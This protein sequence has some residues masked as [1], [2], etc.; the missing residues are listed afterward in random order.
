MNSDEK[1]LLIHGINASNCYIYNQFSFL[2]NIGIH[3]QDYTVTRLGPPQSDQITALKTS[4]P[5]HIEGVSEGGVE[6]D[7]LS[8][9]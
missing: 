6:E 4:R 3:L 9:E 8:Y 1:G 2:L 7:V 5:K